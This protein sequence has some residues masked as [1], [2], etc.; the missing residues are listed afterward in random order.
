MV[1]N[2]ERKTLLTHTFLY[3]PAE[4]DNSKVAKVVKIPHSPIHMFFRGYI[5]G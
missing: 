2:E 3:I 4:Q 5:R 1:G